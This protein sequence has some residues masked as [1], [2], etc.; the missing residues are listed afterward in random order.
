MLKLNKGGWMALIVLMVGG[1]NW[2]LIGLFDFN[3]VS[4]IFGDM[5]RMSRIIYSLIGLAM[6]YTVF[7]G[8]L[9]Y[10]IK[11]AGTHKPHP[12]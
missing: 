4:F 7:E 9:T 6:L 12:A 5:T 11:G 2:G 8:L 3:L 10:R 1:L